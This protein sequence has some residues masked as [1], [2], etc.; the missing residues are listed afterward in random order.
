LFKRVHIFVVIFLLISGIFGQAFGGTTLLVSNNRELKVNS[1]SYGKNMRVLVE[2]NSERYYY[3]LNNK[4]E[5]LP[6][7]LGKGNYNIKVLENISGNRYRV[8][9]KDTIFIK[10][11]NDK[12]S[13]LVS[14]QPVYWKEGQASKLAKELTKNKEST[15]DKVEEIYDYITQ[16]IVYDYDKIKDL[17][18]DYV[19]N[20]EQ[21][22]KSKSG[23]CYDYA[24]LMAGMLRSLNIPTKLVKGYKNDLNN[25]HAWNE[26]LIEDKWVIIDTTY[27]AAFVKA[28]REVDMIKSLNEYNKIREY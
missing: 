26:V 1:T 2:K 16:N 8:V 5:I 11:F 15:I 10:D 18:D 12:E 27:D 23:I 7:Q 17:T 14:A 21:T 24:A 9:S 3:S 19:P 20:I 6:L 25:Y 22:L 4:E 13:F 28:N